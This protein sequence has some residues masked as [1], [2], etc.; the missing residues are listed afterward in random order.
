MDKISI[1]VQD[2]T[3]IIWEGLGDSCS[4]VNTLGPFDILAQH[5]QFV[6]P[7][8]GDIIVRDNTKI[9]WNFTLTSNA[10]CRVKDNQVEIWLGV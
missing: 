6:T 9:I 2:K 4:M 10:I 1:K 8:Q 5:T 7:I 3:S